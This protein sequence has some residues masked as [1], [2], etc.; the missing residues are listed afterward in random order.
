MVY[1]DKLNR[2]IEQRHNIKTRKRLK[3]AIPED[4]IAEGNHKLA[5]Y[6]PECRDLYGRK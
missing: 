1:I 4:F 6:F 5:R 2:G 3:P